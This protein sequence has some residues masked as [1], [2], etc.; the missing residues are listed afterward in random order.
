MAT[1]PTVPTHPLQAT[2]RWT[3]AVRA[4]ECSRPDALVDDP[5][6]ERLAGADGMAWL[7]TRPSASVLPIVVRTRYFDDWLRDVAVAP[8]IPQVVLLGAGLDTRAWRL[9]WAA[10]T[11]ML[12]VDRAELLDAKDTVLGEAGAVAR[13]VR[14]PVPADL[15]GDWPTAL[16]RAGF[17][18][19]L[20]TAWLAEGVLFY[21]PTDVIG[22]ILGAVTSLSSAG[23]RLGLDI[24]NRAVLESPHTRAWLD[25]QAAAGAPWIGW[26]DDPAGSL[27][28]L[29]WHATLVQPGEPGA[30]HGR[31]T[32]PVPPASVPGLPHHWYVTAIRA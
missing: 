11:T 8:A 6:A 25:M 7:A 13:C 19:R 20:P 10:G 4:G 14:R 26:L 31:W 16:A 17:D 1:S 12:E 9:P 24:L 15:A 21:L 18:R 27:A 2:A 23:S 32:L 30:N 5:W 28:G 29:G 3:A 22:A